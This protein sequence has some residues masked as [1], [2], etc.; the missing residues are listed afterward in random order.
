MPKLSPDSK[1]YFTFSAY[2][3]ITNLKAQ[4][5]RAPFLKILPEG[6]YKNF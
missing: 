3:S 4:I 1:L 6:M 5:S 2:L